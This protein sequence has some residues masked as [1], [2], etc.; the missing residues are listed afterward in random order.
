MTSA[1]HNAECVVV[2]TSVPKA[3]VSTQVPTFETS[4][5]DQTREKF[6]E[7]RGRRELGST[8]GG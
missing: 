8:L 1:V 7:A 4:A 5:E 2:V 3:T 6:L